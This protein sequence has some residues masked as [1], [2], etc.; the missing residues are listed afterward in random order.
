M[1]IARFPSC[2]PA[3]LL[4]ALLT[5]V[6]ATL[7][8]LGSAA[9]NQAPVV[10]LT[11]P[12]TGAKYTAPASIALAATAT[13]SNGSIARVDFYS[14][15]TVIA[16]TTTAPY[17]ANWTNVPAGSYTLKAT[18]VDN[19]GKSGSSSTVTVTVTTVTTVI[20][21]PVAGAVLP[22]DP[23]GVTGTFT[24]AADTTVI[25]TGGAGH[26][27]LATLSGNT[28]SAGVTLA[29]GANVI[30]VGV[31][32]RDGTSEITT[33]TITA[34]PPPL[35]VL[36][37]PASCGPFAIP[38]TITL[39]ADALSPGGSIARVEFLDNSALVGTINGAPYTMTYAL[40]QAGTR[41][42]SARVTD[43]IGQSTTSSPFTVTVT[44]A[45]PVV[46]LTSPPAGSTYRVGA[47]VPFAATAV[48]PDGTVARVE[49]LVDG[50]I[51][52]TRTSSPYS[53][54]V[55]IASS[56]PH[57]VSARAVDNTGMTSTSASVAITVIANQ[58]PAV[59]LTSP[60]SGQSF[61]TGA[62]VPLAATASDA[63]GSIAKVEFFANG[64]LIATKIVSPYTANWIS[65][66]V[67]NVTLMARATDND[68]ATTDS[69]GVTVT[70]ATIT[71]TGISITAP[72]NNSTVTT[73][74][75]NIDMTAQAANGTLT[76]IEL[77]DGAT[78]L[79]SVATPAVTTL[80][81]TYTWS[82]IPPGSHTLTAK[83]TDSNGV[84]ATSAAVNI[85]VPVPATI[86]LSTL[87]SYYIAPAGID[88]LANVTAAS[89][90]T[91]DK[92]E[93][94]S[95]GTLVGTVASPPYS[96]RLANTGAGSYTFTAKVTDSQ[97]LT[98]ASNP[99]NVTVSSG[100]TLTLTS[101]LN[102]STVNNDESVL[103]SGSVQAPPNSAVLVNGQLAI[104]TAD[105][106]FFANSVP[107]A[108]GPNTITA[109]LTAP[110]GETATQSASVTR[111]VNG[112]LPTAGGVPTPIDF[113]VTV[114]P[115]EGIINPGDK[116]P[117]SVTIE[118]PANKPFASM[119]LSCGAPN[120]GVP[121]GL[122]TYQ[123]GY[124]SPGV[125]TVLL[126]VKD[127]LDVVIY[128]KSNTVVVRSGLMQDMMIRSVFISMTDSLR[129]G[130][131]SRAGNIITGGAAEG[132]MMLFNSLQQEGK[133]STALDR[134]GTLRGATVG[135]DLAELI[136]SRDTPQ[137]TVAYP[138]WILRGPD[139]IW[140][141]ESM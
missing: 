2:S 50:N 130:N 54:N 53:A 29:P 1:K 18:A 134:L 122:G 64:T 89:G 137:G 23:I 14:G 47:P 42:F 94:F 33:R 65:A 58:S 17:T 70:V 83:A 21:S 27:S 112:G 78:L 4:A 26:S 72:A 44:S 85:T 101:G 60:M 67:G 35:I 92:V 132:Y 20:T 109:T 97:P 116:F 45:P 123:C 28:F 111:T 88:L 99:V 86:T 16:T 131:L 120:P 75:L 96:F 55:P 77:F 108:E 57:N 110:D 39:T 117:V 43:A 136:L 15:S 107:L 76:K 30:E 102:G 9:P 32:R 7:P 82:S 3:A 100:V 90:T 48:D 127:G 62:A 119:T 115:G 61:T 93:F 12:A 51:V 125:H 63:D 66:G 135:T 11:S 87:S 56:G 121:A 5:L 41:S 138:V 114:S 84:L 71:Q 52:A 140:R 126:T 74:T 69:A 103:V 31:A 141:I 8:R 34:V 59:T 13:D 105:G 79:A 98:V 22:I 6:A 24:G 129:A 37:S 49:F 46:T 128:S 106:T 19:A 133:L 80:N 36:T 118:S 25:V 73:P 10:T 91:I 68:G 139:G 40:S 104:L 113:R 124:T 81:F 95:G 38:T